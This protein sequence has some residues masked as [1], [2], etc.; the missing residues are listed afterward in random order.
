MDKLRVVSTPDGIRWT[1]A[2]SAFG[3]LYELNSEAELMIIAVVATFR[4]AHK[5]TAA[6]RPLFGRSGRPRLAEQL[7]LHSRDG[8]HGQ[9]AN[10][11]DPRI[12]RRLA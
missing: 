3:V 10:R 1:S 4:T 9:A 5:Y 2:Y 6:Q 7:A 11:P 8:D 12:K